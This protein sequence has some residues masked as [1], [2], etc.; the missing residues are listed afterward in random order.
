MVQLEK[1]HAPS[2]YVS[3]NCTIDNSIYLGLLPKVKGLNNLGNTCF[4]N[5]VMQC[6][7]QTHPLTQLIDQQTSKGA[8]LNLNVGFT[9][10]I[11]RCFLINSENQ[12]DFYL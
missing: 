9:L 5:S 12:I 11:Y 1:K 6:L 10:N 7:S 8:N 4:F 3:N 2:N